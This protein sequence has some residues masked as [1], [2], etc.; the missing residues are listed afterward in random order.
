MYRVE[1]PPFEI[2]KSN[3]ACTFPSCLFVNVK[4]Q[5]SGTLCQIP[6]FPKRSLRISLAVEEQLYPAQKLR[7]MVVS[8]LA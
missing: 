1:I 8:H 6:T 7:S 2:P 5:Q 4:P 3:C